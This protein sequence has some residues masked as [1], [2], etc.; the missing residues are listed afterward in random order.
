MSQSRHIVRVALR[1][2]GHIWEVLTVSFDFKTYCVGV[3][4]GSKP[5]LFQMT[6]ERGVVLPIRLLK[7]LPAT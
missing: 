7:I 3:V 4:L 1:C 5:I 6:Q 2:K